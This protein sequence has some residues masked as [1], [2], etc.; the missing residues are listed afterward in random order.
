MTPL[1]LT[2]T[3]NFPKHSMTI[4][5]YYVHSS[6]FIF[7]FQISATM[8]LNL[9]V[10]LK[11][12]VLLG[13]IDMFERKRMEYE[14]KYMIHMPSRWIYFS[15]PTY[16]KNI[17]EILKITII[18]ITNGPVRKHYCGGGGGRGFPIFTS[19]IWPSTL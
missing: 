2:V 11:E 16:F 15:D 13:D 18:K 3:Y 6:Y 1:G 14:M 10:R 12:I 17:Q 5:Y 19:E 7:H 8:V 9:L 4:G